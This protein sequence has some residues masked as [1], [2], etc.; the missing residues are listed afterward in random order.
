[1]LYT[2]KSNTKL[3]VLAKNTTN[4]N[5]ALT[6]TEFTTI[7]EVNYLFEFI[8]ETTQEAYYCISADLSHYKNRYNLFTIIEGVDAP[9]NGSLILGGHGFYRYNVYEQ[10][11]T[12]LDPT[13]L[14]KVESGKMRLTNGNESYPTHT[15]TTTIKVHEPS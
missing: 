9:L 5:I 12:S 13:G 3:I 14:N 4:E 2:S 1:M 15:I 11:G 10:E 8:N 7:T 6:L